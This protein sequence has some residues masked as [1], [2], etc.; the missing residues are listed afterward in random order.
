MVSNKGYAEMFG[1]HIG[2]TELSSKSRARPR[3]PKHDGKGLL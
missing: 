1:F 2:Y 3:Q